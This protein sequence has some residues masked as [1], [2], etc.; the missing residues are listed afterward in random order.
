MPWLVLVV[1]TMHVS[2][3]EMAAGDRADAP[4]W[5]HTCSPIGTGSSP[6]TLT[7]L[8]QEIPPVAQTTSLGQEFTPIALSCTT[9]GQVLKLMHTSGATP[10]TLTPTLMSLGQVITLVALVI[11]LMLLF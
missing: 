9:L 10:V 5:S 7:T 8:R 11:I 1:R 6:V 4:E 3:C 2:M